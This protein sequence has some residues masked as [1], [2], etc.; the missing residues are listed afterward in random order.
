MLQEVVELH[1]SPNAGDAL[2]CRLSSTLQPDKNQ[3]FKSISWKE[4]TELDFPKKRLI[5]LT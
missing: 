4:A 5:L 1:P 3:V 2:E